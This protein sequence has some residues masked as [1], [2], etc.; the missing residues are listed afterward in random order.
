MKNKNVL[1]IWVVLFVVLQVWFVN[2]QIEVPNIDGEYISISL[3]QD[4]DSRIITFNQKGSFAEVEG[5]R[6]ENIQP[7]EGSLNPSF[8]KIDNEGNILELDLTTNEN[9]GSYLING[10]P[11]EVPANSRIVYRDNNIYLP[12]K[13]K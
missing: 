6:F 2:S 9:G 4:G 3:S 13:S 12:K 1:I 7:T 11:I 5:N 8:I 10:V